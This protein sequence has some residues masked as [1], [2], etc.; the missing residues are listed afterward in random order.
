MDG[1]NSDEGVVVIAA[2][3]RERMLD[4][5]LVRAGRFDKRIKVGLPDFAERKVILEIHLRMK[6]HEVG[7]Q[8]LEMVARA[9][10]GMSG[11]E[12]ENIVNDAMITAIE[13]GEALTG[14]L[15][16]ETAK[17]KVRQMQNFNQEAAPPMN[18]N[19]PREYNLL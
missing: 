10:K 2:T 17:D 3:N 1:F 16:G 6:K 14:V 11:A 15:L 13:R 9:T 4:K 5:A 19:L 18:N 12:L 8:D 7:E